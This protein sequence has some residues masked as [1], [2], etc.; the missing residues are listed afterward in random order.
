MSD[1]KFV[2]VCKIHGVDGQFVVTELEMA[3][4][5][6]KMDTITN[7]YETVEVKYEL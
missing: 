3:E 6:R 5:W 1:F 7:Y 4:V 2:Y